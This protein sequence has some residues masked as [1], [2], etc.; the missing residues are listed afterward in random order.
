MGR[1]LAPWFFAAFLV[2][3]CREPVCSEPPSES[4]HQGPKAAG[5]ARIDSFG[6]PLPAEALARMGSNRLRLPGG[7][8]IGALAF[9]LD[10]RSLACAIFTY[11]RKTG[12]LIIVDVVT[13]K[14][15]Q[16]FTLDKIAISDVRFSADGTKL[17]AIGGENVLERRLFDAAAAHRPSERRQYAGSLA[18]WPLAGVV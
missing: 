5:A 11:P 14:F 17:I 9:S 4:P 16:R 2:M 8:N 1:L 7:G 10:G 15:K 13:G 3:A 12:I 18:R 6:V